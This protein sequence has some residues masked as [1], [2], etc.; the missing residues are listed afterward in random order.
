MTNRFSRI[1]LVCVVLAL[2]LGACGKEQPGAELPNGRRLLTDSAAAMDGVN[3]LRFLLNVQ[4]DRP[5]NFQITDAS[6]AITRDGGVTATAKVLQGGQLV[7]YEYIVTGNIPYLK[8]PTGGFRQ[9]PEAIYNRI[10]NPT[11]LLAGER[12]L[13]NA[14]RKVTEATTEEEEE[15]EGVDTYRIKGKLNPAQVEG[16]SLLASGR[17]SET[18]LWVSKENKQLVRARMPFTVAGQE[19]ET[20]VTVTLSNYNEPVDIRPPV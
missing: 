6:G 20:V 17:V 9:V 10:F 5:S 15:V 12:S 4:G 2:V 7:E 14:L 11:G 1:V 13:P 3:S 19:G 16:L 8:G 18:T